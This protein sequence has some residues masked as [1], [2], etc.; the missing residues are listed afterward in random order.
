M[1]RLPLK[2]RQKNAF[3]EGGA[4]GRGAKNGRKL[5]GSEMEWQCLN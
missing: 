4:G 1:R 3:N 5:W 2:L